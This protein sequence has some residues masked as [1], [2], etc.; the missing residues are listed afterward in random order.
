MNIKCKLIGHWLDV[1]TDKRIGNCRR[2][3]QS[4]EVGY[5]GMGTVIIKKLEGGK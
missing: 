4:F 3:C 1:N 2:C 5:D